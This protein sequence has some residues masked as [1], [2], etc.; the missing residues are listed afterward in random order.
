MTVSVTFE[1]RWND[2]G[3]AEM[4]QEIREY[5][6]RWVLQPLRGSRVAHIAWNPD[7]FEI[8][9]DTPFRVIADY[10]TELSPRS[11][12]EDDPDRHR[13]THWPS[14]DVET[15]LAAPIVSAVAFK[16]GGLRIGYR[17]GWNMFASYRSRE[18]STAIFSG[19]TLIW[20]SSG[21]ASQ[22]IYPVVTIDKWTGRIIEAPP[23]PP[24]PAN[25]DIN[26]AS[27]DI[28]S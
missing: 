12:A 3:R 11:L 24:R 13:I 26:Y 10:E 9:F 2:D 25:L 14:T 20:N 6:D 18:S 19:R 27:D 28:N 1:T 15:F 7:D 23:W 8:L 5:E 4:N 21:I 16:S 17:N 22:T